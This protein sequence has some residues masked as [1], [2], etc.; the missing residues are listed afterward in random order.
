[1]KCGRPSSYAHTAL[2]CF[3]LQLKFYF[4]TATAQAVV[5]RTQDIR[6]IM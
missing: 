2:A 5:T 6:E 4:Y 3:E 1:M